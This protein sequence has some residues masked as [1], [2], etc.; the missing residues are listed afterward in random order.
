MSGLTIWK[1]DASVLFDSNSR[2]GRITG[3][4][5]HEGPGNVTRTITVPTGPGKTPWMLVFPWGDVS[6]LCQNQGGGAWL[7]SIDIAAGATALVF[8]GER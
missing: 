1:P 5:T 7:Y 3:M 8:W 6:G 2:P 4:A